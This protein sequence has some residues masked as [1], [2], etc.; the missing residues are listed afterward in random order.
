MEVGWGGV[1]TRKDIKEIRC[2]R[3][4]LLSQSF[5]YYISIFWKSI[6]FSTVIMGS[7][8]HSSKGEVTTTLIAV[9]LVKAA[10]LQ[11]RKK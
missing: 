9:I 6:F 8:Q 3:G 7:K 1:S 10:V 4:F 2:Q 5:P 11:C